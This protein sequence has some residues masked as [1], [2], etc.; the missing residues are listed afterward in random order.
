MILKMLLS[1]S[2]KKYISGLFKEVEEGLGHKL[3][4]LYFKCIGSKS[5]KRKIG[6]CL[7]L[8]ECLGCFIEI[9]T[10]EIGIVFAMI[11]IIF[12]EDNTHYPC[13]SIKISRAKIFVWKFIVPE[14]A[15][16]YFF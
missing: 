14:P 7:F 5:F 3:S 10:Y 11:M 15:R 1:P 4:S 8:M 6:G 13:F 12:E 2:N 9:T 16:L